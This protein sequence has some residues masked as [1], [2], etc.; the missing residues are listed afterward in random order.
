MVE[1]LGRRNLLLLGAVGMCVCQCKQARPISV[2]LQ[3]T[4]IL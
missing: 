1:K 3:L 4:L 2:G